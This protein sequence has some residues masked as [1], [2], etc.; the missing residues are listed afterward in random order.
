MITQQALRWEVTEPT[1]MTWEHHLLIDLGHRCDGLSSAV[2]GGGWVNARYIVNRSVPKGW[3]CRNPIED[4]KGYLERLNLDPAACVGLLTAVSIKD[5]QVCTLS[6]DEWEVTCFATVGVSNAARAGG[7]FALETDPDATNPGTINLIL[8]VEGELS[9]AALVGAVQTATEAKTAALQDARVTT[10]FGEN[11][12][13]TTTDTVTVVNHASQ[14]RALYAGPA[15]VPGYLIGR[16][17]YRTVHTAL[18]EH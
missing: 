3:D 13:G 1:E 2:L 8:V 15:T 17:V 9:P 10:R 4:M 12:T 5:L 11:A 18:K 7:R 6:Q 14:P 16:A